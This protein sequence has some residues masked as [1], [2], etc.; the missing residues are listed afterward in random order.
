MK[1]SEFT[2]GRGAEPAKTLVKDLGATLVLYA[3][4]KTSYAHAVFAF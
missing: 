4:F 1:F 2:T 3:T